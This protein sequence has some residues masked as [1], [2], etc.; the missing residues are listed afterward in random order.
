[1]DAIIELVSKN[2][3]VSTLVGAAIIGVIG[4]LWSSYQNRKD[5]NSILSFLEASKENTEYTFRSTEAI[6]SHANLTEK[7]VV[8]LCAKHPKIKRNSKE[9]Q[10]WRLVE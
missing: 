7:R 3:L 2:A 1:M 6:A 10:S 5:A 9:K 4:W 8:S